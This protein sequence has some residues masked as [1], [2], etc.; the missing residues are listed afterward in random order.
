M[1]AEKTAAI[2]STGA[3]ICTASDNSCLMHINGALHR[4]QTGVKTLH[5]AEIL[6]GE[7]E[8]TR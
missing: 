1:L 8:V 7:R 4:Q 6:A 5:L 2:L 3:K